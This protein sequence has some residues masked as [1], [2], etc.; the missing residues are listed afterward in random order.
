V[1][2][3]QSSVVSHSVFDSERLLAFS[4]LLSKSS[5]EFE[6]LLQGKSMEPLMPDGSKIRVRLAADDQFMVGQ[7]LTYV[8]K[9]RVVAHRLVRSMKSWG[10]RYLIT[11][12]DSTV[13]CD[14][15]ILAT[16]VLGLV[17]GFSTTGH[18]QPISPPP[19]RWFGFRWLAFLIS[20]LVGAILKVSP[21]AAVWTTKLIIRMHGMIQRATGFLK[22]RAALGLL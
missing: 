14:L 3:N 10:H 2:L 15:P 8:R 11:R 9:D 6:F 4:G 5:R 13:C 12:G 18:W 22:R 16:S 17:T 20:S 1:R 19:E 21:S 7:V